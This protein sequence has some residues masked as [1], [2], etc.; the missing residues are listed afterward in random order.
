MQKSL[1][2]AIVI[3]I[4]KTWIM[5]FINKLYV[6]NLYTEDTKKESFEECFRY[7]K[8]RSVKCQIHYR[9]ILWDNL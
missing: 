6:K 3:D 8:V 4:S 1:K 7:K 9:K 2:H 5:T